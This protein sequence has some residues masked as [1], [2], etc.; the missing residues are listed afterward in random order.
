MKR[1]KN[2]SKI[3]NRVARANFNN[4]ILSQGGLG[5]EH[6]LVLCVKNR[7]CEFHLTFPEIFIKI[8]TSAGI[9]DLLKKVDNNVKPY[10]EKVKVDAGELRKVDIDTTKG[11]LK[12][13]EIKSLILDGVDRGLNDE[14]SQVVV[15]SRR[16]KRGSVELIDKT[17]NVVIYSTEKSH[18]GE[19][20]V[21]AVGE[22][23][24]VLTHDEFDSFYALFKEQVDR[25]VKL[26]SSYSKKVGVF[27]QETFDFNSPELF[28]GSI[29]KSLQVSVD[30]AV[31]KGAQVDSYERL[32][33]EN[34]Y[35]DMYKRNNRKITILCAK[36]NSGKTYQGIEMIKKTLKENESSQNVMLFPLRVLALQIQ[37]DLEME[38][39]PCSMITGE[40]QIISEHAKVDAMTVEIF[41]T[42]KKY[43]TV[44]L[45]EGQ[46]AF[47]P[48]RSSGYLRVLCGARCDHLIVAC[49]P[50]ALD[51]LTW[52]LGDILGES[53][54]VRTLERLTPLYPIE[55][56]VS[57]DDV[58]DGDLVVAFSRNSIHEIAG[59]LSER[60]LSVGTM[61]G[62]LSPAARKAMLMQYRE[63]GYQVLVASDAIGMGVSAPAQRVLF[64]SIEKYDGNSVR[65][66][67]DE[68][69]RQIAGRA[70]RYG[71]AE[72]GEAGVLEGNDPERLIEL[73]NSEPSPLPLPKILYVSPDKT[74][75]MAAEEIGIEQA[76]KVWSRAVK[77]TPLYGV[78][79]SSM[80]E[81]LIKAKWL[82][83]IIKSGLL[84]HSEGIRLL[85]VTFPMGGKACR[86]ELYKTW[87]T[88]ACSDGVVTPPAIEKA[89]DLVHLEYLSTDITLM[90]Q[91]SR[92]FPDAFK[93]AEKLNQQQ[94]QLGEYIA[95]LI[96]KR[97]AS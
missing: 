27:L 38:G 65:P 96:D 18:S 45:D 30:L 1:N 55:K 10:A 31:S 77:K 72:S 43:D 44:F 46:L 52:F 97:Y 92:I 39:V 3:L 64:S 2:I 12:F 89:N 14:L 75:L 69:Y 5:R 29:F 61:Y 50:A 57:Y 86:L 94:T 19:P 6:V 81:L 4:I 7:L 36:T 58:V 25:Q 76:L 66:L 26:I 60:G 74:Q 95:Q 67:L 71:Y 41:D 16:Y 88:T 70:G 8:S 59:R 17:I 79:D 37:H 28:V 51:R 32:V 90:I 73:I 62:A 87:I 13:H 93:S 47:E 85:F 83:G 49:A 80:D 91:L 23:D 42:S 63:N 22:I 84:S 35:H 68:E 34:P 82:D 21:S 48:D 15:F 24:G 11:A 54:D 9:I 56:P 53:F 40:E 78:N 33:A 20:L